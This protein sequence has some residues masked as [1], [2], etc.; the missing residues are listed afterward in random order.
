MVI[1]LESTMGSETGQSLLG[2]DTCRRVLSRNKNYSKVMALYGELKAFVT[3]IPGK[4]FQ[5]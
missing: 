4:S 2:C 3:G 1:C 5:A